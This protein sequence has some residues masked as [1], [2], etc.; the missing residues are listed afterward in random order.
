VDQWNNSQLIPNF[1]NNWYR[2][3]MRTTMDRVGRIVLP[4]P[5]RDALGLAPADEFDVFIDGS[6]IRL[7]PKKNSKRSITVVDGWPVLTAVPGL[8]VTD[9]DVQAIRDGDQR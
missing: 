8:R 1:P 3:V 5:V 4:K 9:Q 6:S 2:N 7:E